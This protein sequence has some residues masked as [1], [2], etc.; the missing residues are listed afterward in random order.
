M[1]SI[2]SLFLSFFLFGC[3]TTPKAEKTENPY[4]EFIGLNG[5]I[6]DG[7]SYSIVVRYSTTKE[8]KECTQNNWVAGV[9]TGFSEDFEYFPERKNGS[10]EIMVPLSEISKETECE[11]QAS[12]IFLRVWDEKKGESPSSMASLFLLYENSFRG[13][14]SSPVLY[15]EDGF[16]EKGADLLSKERIALNKFYPLDIRRSNQTR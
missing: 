13:G 2:I 16:W 5:S 3:A 12:I 8:T 10:H 4:N 6:E 11:W 7:L 15:K 14:T 1:K 9:R